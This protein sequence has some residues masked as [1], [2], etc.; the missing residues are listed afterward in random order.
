MII[1]HSFYYLIARGLP[2]LLN[3]AGLIIF[4][5]LLKPEDF[6]K[7]ALVLS[8]VGLAH[9]LLFQW[10]QLVLGRYLP[11]HPNSPEL[12]LRPILGIYLIIASATIF[13]GAII[14]SWAPEYYDTI[15]SITILILVNSWIQINLK[16][17]S[18]Q[19]KPKIYGY[20]LGTKSFLSIA[21][22]S[23]LVIIGAGA[24]SPIIGLIAG[25]IISWLV[26]GATSWI[27]I[28]PSLPSRNILREYLS[29]GIPLSITFALDWVISSSDR[30]IISWLINEAAAGIYS[31]GYDF[32][33]QTLGLILIIINT[34][35]NPLVIRIY[36]KN[37]L[38]AAK[39]QLKI[40]GDLIITI[41]IICSAYLTALAPTVS[42]IFFG[43]EFQGK[44]AEIIPWIAVGAAIAG[45]KQFYLDM[46]F[47]ISKN[48]KAQIYTS[49]IAA[50]ANTLLNYIFIPIFGILGACYATVLAYIIAAILSGYFGKRL[51][52]MPAFVPLLKNG[53]IIGLFA[54]IG[55]ISVTKL[56]M[57]NFATL[58]I[59]TLSFLL[60]ATISAF[61]LN[62]NNSRIHIKKLISSIQKQK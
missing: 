27:K 16:L 15:I 29:Y 2:G 34:A 13:T 43:K 54:Y 6:G 47:Q 31:A 60:C 56:G 5:R 57:N 14:S 4:T 52:P 8:Y 3:F 12:V 30:V 62:A 46:P 18:T 44:I 17:F 42:N 50:V 22:G 41:A 1:Q 28:K 21:I 49:I 53:I 33:Q 32:A 25:S 45:I 38:E 59:G 23:W 51:F 48:S 10:M 20:L 24:Q 58:A 36:E 9:A 11:A 39:H 61:S 35:A 55:A 37:G 7:Y 26:F 40:N 19:L